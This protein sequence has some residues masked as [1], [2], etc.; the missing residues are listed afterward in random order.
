MYAHKLCTRATGDGQTQT[1]LAIS[2]V[3]GEN[4]LQGLVAAPS[5]VT[6]DNLLRRLLKGTSQIIRL[7]SDINSKIAPELVD[8]SIEALVKP[9]VGTGKK[10]RR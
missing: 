2:E 3:L 1:S 8:H 9:Q 4:N 5:N 7:G 6:A 10:K